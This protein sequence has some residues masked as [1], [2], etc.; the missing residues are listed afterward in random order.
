MKLHPVLLPILLLVALSGCAH[1]PAQAVAVEMPVPVPCPPPPVLAR[2]ALPIADLQPDSPPAAVLRA[3]TASIK[4]L[5]G[6]AT[7]LETL[8]NGYRQEAR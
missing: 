1:A 5:A 6:Y 3:Y 2:P 8:L 4:A 7:E